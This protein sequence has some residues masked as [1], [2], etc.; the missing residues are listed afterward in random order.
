MLLDSNIEGFYRLPLKRVLCCSD[1]QT[2]NMW[3]FLALGK[4][5]LEWS[6]FQAG[7][8]LTWNMVFFVTLLKAVG[9]Q[10]S[11]LTLVLKTQES[12]CFWVYTR[13]SMGPLTVRHGGRLSGG[14]SL[15][16]WTI[17]PLTDSREGGVSAFRCM[18]T[19]NSTRLQ[20]RVPIQRSQQ[21]L[22]FGLLLSII[23][24]KCR[25]PRPSC[26]RES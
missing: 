12:L 19:G 20:W 16:L 9:V 18:P 24:V 5:A 3:F 22:R 4:A 15:S 17:F 6:W 10:W 13:T 11:L 26:P 23:M 7:L 21:I 1:R 2:M 8:I 25:P 14:S